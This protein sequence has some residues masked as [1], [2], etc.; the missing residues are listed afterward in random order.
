MKNVIAVI[1]ATIKPLVAA[2]VLEL[3]QKYLQDHAAEFTKA[4]EKPA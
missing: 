2:M 3:V 1:W 4:N